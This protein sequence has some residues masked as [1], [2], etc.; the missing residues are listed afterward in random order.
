MV[1]FWDVF[2]NEN[3]PCALSQWAT[4]TL[5]VLSA[6]SERSAAELFNSGASSVRGCRELA[7]H[8]P[9]GAVCWSH[10]MLTVR[11]I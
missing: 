7:D 8:A 10:E 1:L 4:E 6:L 5:T 11:G 9:S 3:E 2:T